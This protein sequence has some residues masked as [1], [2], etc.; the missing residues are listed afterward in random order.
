VTEASTLTGKFRTRAEYA[1]GIFVSIYKSSKE[2]MKQGAVP[3][4]SGNHRTLSMAEPDS[5]LHHP[6]EINTD[7]SKRPDTETRS[8]CPLFAYQS[9]QQYLSNQAEPEFRPLILPKKQYRPFC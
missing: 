1:H 2:S 6:N 3:S 7:Y 9:K 5:A 4:R 8:D